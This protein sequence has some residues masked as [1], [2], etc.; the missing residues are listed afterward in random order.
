LNIS[1]FNNSNDTLLSGE[2]IDVSY[3]LN[4]GT[5][6]NEVITL[7]SDLLLDSTVDYSFTSTLDLTITPNNI[8]DVNC[9]LPIDVNTSNDTLSVDIDAIG[10]PSFTLGDDIYTTNPVGIVL[11]APAGYASYLWHLKDFL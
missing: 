9:S 8:I 11:T 1:V 10:Y 5:A 7:I 6:V 4:S 2:T 3:S